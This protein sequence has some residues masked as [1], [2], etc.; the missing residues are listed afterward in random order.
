MYNLYEF[1]TKNSDFILPELNKSIKFGDIVG[2]REGD[3]FF[4]RR[5]KTDTSIS[6]ATEYSSGN[7]SSQ[8]HLMINSKGEYIP[9]TGPIVA[10]CVLSL[11]KTFMRDQ[12]ISEVLM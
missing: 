4:I 6:I 10:N 12:K 9:T 3:C 1:V 11:Y 5:Y 2:Y 7:Y 8:G